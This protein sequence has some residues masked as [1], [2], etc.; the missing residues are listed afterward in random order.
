VS[1]NSG[2][3][4]VLIAHQ[5][6]AERHAFSL[7]A[8]SQSVWPE[9]WY[10]QPQKRVV[11]ELFEFSFHAYRVNEFT[12]IKSGKFDMKELS[13]SIMEIDQNDLYP[14]LFDYHYALNRIRHCVSFKFGSLNP[15][16]GRQMWAKNK[17][18]MAGFVVVSSAQEKIE[19]AIPLFPIAATFLHFVRPVSESLINSLVRPDREGA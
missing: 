11:E 12:G 13:Q 16:R 18:V 2:I 14:W 5:R 19:V 1:L 4:P 3:L 9:E 10:R 7:S 17:N 15:P 8:F 6:A